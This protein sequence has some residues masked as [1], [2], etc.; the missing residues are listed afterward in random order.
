MSS[1]T[2]P[3]ATRPQT[4]QG[5]APSAAQVHRG[6]VAFPPDAAGQPP[7]V[8]RIEWA[9]NRVE[10]LSE[11]LFGWSAASN[12]DARRSLRLLC[13]RLFRSSA[14]AY[15]QVDR[16]F[17]RLVVHLASGFQATPFVLSQISQ[18]L[19]G[20]LDTIDLEPIILWDEA[21][22][23]SFHLG[24][25]G[26]LV[27]TW[28]VL[29]SSPGSIRLKQPAIHHEAL[30]P[31]QLQA[32][33]EDIPAVGRFTI[34]EKQGLLSIQA[35]PGQGLDRALIVQ[36]LEQLTTSSAS[37]SLQSVYPQARMALPLATLGLAATAQWFNPVVW[38][39]AAV[40]IV[41]LNWKAMLRSIKDLGQGQLGLPLLTTLIVTGTLAGG[42]LTASALFTVLARYW[43]N[44]YAR[45]LATARRDW[46][47]Q[48]AMPTGTYQVVKNHRLESKPAGLIK[49]G[50][51]LE[52]TAPADIPADGQWLEGDATLDYPFGTEEFSSHTPRLERKVFAG[53]HLQSGRM[54][55]QVASTGHNTRMAHIRE[56]LLRSTGT[57]RGTSAL[58]KH[59]QRFGEKTV[60]PTLALAG[61]GLAS[62]G[63]GTAVAIM[64][65]DYATGI[66]MGEGLELLRL[67]S[68][69]LHQGFLIRNAQQLVAADQ[70][71]LWLIET[72]TAK[73]HPFQPA[74]PGQITAEI[75]SPTRIDL[76]HQGQRLT[77]Q[78]FPPM[79][80][81]VDR[82]R[83]LHL[84]RQQGIGQ[85]GWVGN[86]ER[87]PNTAKAADVALSTSSQ[88][89][90]E[91]NPAAAVQL[92][93]N[94]PADWNS[95][96]T[97]VH[98]LHTERDRIR[99]I[100]LAPN[101]LAVAGAFTLG[102]TS[103]ASVA[104]TNAGIWAV[105]RRT[106]HKSSNQKSFSRAESNT[107][108]STTA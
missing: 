37:L 88:L 35:V 86:A 62:G 13:E 74:L 50:D 70:I 18:A 8:S 54:R 103:L 85:I 1:A 33:L 24:R 100:A 66:G 29:E 98:N 41:Y 22:A 3:Q 79:H 20:E 91:S 49:Q 68:N 44:Q 72:D 63:L 53:G 65:P 83:L 21:P 51:I 75:V 10:I 5:H 39:V 2:A 95:L 97:L 34:D 19:A 15:A 36:T 6:H 61:L 56:E 92:S 71:Q 26:Q 93:E 4:T 99:R 11:T 27:T 67:S 82:L 78:G 87:F 14:V 64:R 23:A 30:L 9:E 60:L 25:E 28:Q 59:G 80:N 90:P 84:L 7:V 52:L 106:V 105:H 32:I 31:E 96:L 12:T 57:H 38:P 76:V 107:D 47:S 73:A 58:N 55:L 40:L 45:L 102:F 46:L 42:A 104:L 77:L 108:T 101:I 89:N 69:A 94:T 43:Q 17:H 16:N 81:D 48:L